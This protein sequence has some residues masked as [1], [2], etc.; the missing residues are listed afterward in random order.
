MVGVNRVTACQTAHG[1]MAAAQTLSEKGQSMHLRFFL[2]SLS[3]AVLLTL[4]ATAGREPCGSPVGPIHLLDADGDEM[5]LDNYAER[6]ATALLF[7][8]SRCQA[9]EQSIAEINN[10][11]WIVV[12]PNRL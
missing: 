11:V 8:S 12:V 1:R 9:T 3:L 6:P 5:V 4:S 2:L 7:L 10:F